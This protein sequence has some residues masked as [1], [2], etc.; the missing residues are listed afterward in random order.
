MKYYKTYRNGNQ[1]DDPGYDATFFRR[2][3]TTTFSV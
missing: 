2:D 1:K 3:E